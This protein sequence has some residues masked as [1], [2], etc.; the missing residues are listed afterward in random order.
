MILEQ[1]N[2]ILSIKL[3]SNKNLFQLNVPLDKQIHIYPLSINKIYEHILFIGRIENRKHL[4][5]VSTIGKSSFIDKYDGDLIQSNEFEQS[6][7]LKRCEMN[8]PNAVLIRELFKFT[9]PVLIGLHNSFGFGDRLGLATPGHLRAFSDSDMKPVFAQQ[10]IRELERTGRSPEDVIDAASWAVFQEGYKKGFG[11]DADHL[12]TTD[13]LDLMVK[14]GFTMITIDPGEFVNNE[15]DVLSKEELLEKMKSIPWAELKDSLESFL[16]RYEN[17]RFTITGDFIIKP[18]RKDL[19]RALVKYGNVIAHVIKMYGHLK[20]KFPEYPCE[21]ELSV[22]ETDIPTTP[23]EHF[24]IVNELK[25]L[26]IKPISIAP[27][28]IGDFEKGIDYKGDL[29]EFKMEYLKHVKI[30]EH[31]GPY[32]ISIH[33]GSDKFSI[34][35]IIGACGQ[36]YVHVKTAGTSYLEALRVIVS[37]DPLL[38]REIFDFSRERYPEEKRSYHVSGDLERVP[39]A[40]DCTDEQLLRL[41]KN[42]DVRQVLHVSYGNV[43]TSRD[44][45]GE[46][47][48]RNRILECLKMHEEMHYD[49]LKLHFQRHLKPFINNQ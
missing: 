46:Y 37:V 45:T 5:I 23:L 1:L 27:R 13:D 32:K 47:I 28:F 39:H 18:S 6:V 40:N 20:K 4:Y 19:M 48:F 29:N 49:F 2:E 11:A 14:A 8:H 22:D 36:G 38:F 15:A 26:G 10:S 7:V 3:V 35:E 34:Y 9:S 12:K 21:L 31:L 44:G 25:R 30:A 42:D 33:S 24:L 41:F 17:K 16:T 43:L